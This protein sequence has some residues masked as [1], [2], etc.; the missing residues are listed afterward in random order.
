MREYQEV[1]RRVRS[2]GNDIQ[3][4]VDANA[5]ERANESH[6]TLTRLVAAKIRAAGAI[7]KSNALVDLAAEL[8]P[9]DFLFEMKSSTPRNSRSQVR[10]AIAQLYEYRYLQ[11]SPKAQ[12]VVVIEN[13]LPAELSWMV[14]YV[15]ND[16]GLL[17][18]W[19]GDGRTLHFPEAV[20]DRLGFL[21]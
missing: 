12:M 10:K 19:D 15:V 11:R 13:P 20:R 1:A 3:V 5:R 6:A 17:I 16:R 7:P 21:A 8:G 4:L 9:N 2:A 14:D 18:A